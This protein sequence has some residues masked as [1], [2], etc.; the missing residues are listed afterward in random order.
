MASYL[1]T[2]WTLSVHHSIDAGLGGDGETGVRWFKEAMP[3]R[4]N[5]VTRKNRME[6][7]MKPNLSLDLFW[8]RKKDY[9]DSNKEEP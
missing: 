1:L 4:Q 3:C 2:A 5:V 9:N 7:R 8:A 6:T